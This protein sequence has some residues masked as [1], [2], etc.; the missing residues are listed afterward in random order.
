MVV[1][2]NSYGGFIWFYGDFRIMVILMK[3]SMGVC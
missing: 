3:G 1:I 2:D